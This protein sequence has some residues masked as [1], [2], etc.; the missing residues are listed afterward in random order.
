MPRHDDVY[1]ERRLPS[2]EYHRPPTDEYRHARPSYDD[3]RPAGETYEAAA[4][5]SNEFERPPVPSP[6]NDRDHHY[7]GQQH[8]RGGSAGGR[9]NNFHNRSF[10][11]RPHNFGGQRNDYGERNAGGFNR[12]GRGGGGGGHYGNDNYATAHDYGRNGNDMAPVSKRNP[13]ARNPFDGPQIDAPV[14]VEL[15]AAEQRAWRDN[16]RGGGGGERDRNNGRQFGQQNRR[17]GGRRFNDNGR[18]FD[19]DRGRGAD[20]NDR[21]GGGGGGGRERDRDRSDGPRDRAAKNFPNNSRRRSEDRQPRR[22]LSKNRR[23]QH[24]GHRDRPKS[25]EKSYA[26]RS[27]RTTSE[28]S[29][30][31]KKRRTGK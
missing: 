29:G 30:R 10:N 14:E 6:A 1:A 11:E 22:D 20:R 2:N 25:I 18:R 8:Y 21:N 24:S 19:N 7:G 12:R 9:P 4:W 27:P 15:P 26:N 31:T 5:R 17:D 13:F 3:R 23:D 28:R 16:G